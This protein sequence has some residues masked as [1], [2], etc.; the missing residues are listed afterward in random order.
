MSTFKSD[1]EKT[2]ITIRRKGENKSNLNL[3][4]SKGHFSDD[5]ALNSCSTSTSS[6]APILLPLAHNPTPLALGLLPLAPASLPLAPNLTPLALAPIPLAP[7]L[8]PLAPDLT[9]LALNPLPLALAPLP[10][11]LDLSP[12]APGFT[13]LLQNQKHFIHELVMQDI[14]ASPICMAT[15]K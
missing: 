15:I 4:P 5:F 8:L 13:P 6:L 12:L 1:I 2:G 10:L 3:Y 14:R 9:P 11:A 7:G